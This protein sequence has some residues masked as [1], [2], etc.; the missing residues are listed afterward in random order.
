MNSSNL[1]TETSIVLSNL[2]PTA[3][4]HQRVWSWRSKFLKNVIISRWRRLKQN[5]KLNVSPE[6]Y[7]RFNTP[8]RLPRRMQ[9]WLTS[10]KTSKWPKWKVVTKRSRQTSMWLN[11]RS[12]RWRKEFATRTVATETMQANNIV[13][14]W[15][16]MEIATIALVI[17]VTTSMH[18]I[19][20]FQ[21]ILKK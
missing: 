1:A 13:L 12:A 18:I 3:R 21:A 2:L 20:T 8:F 17:G 10:Q 15:T 7:R 19:I 11:V 4:L 16:N 14:R 9:I 5:R 6:I